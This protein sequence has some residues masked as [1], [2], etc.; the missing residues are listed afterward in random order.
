MRTL[1]YNYLNTNH[2]CSKIEILGL[3]ILLIIKLS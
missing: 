3:H 2:N 1:N